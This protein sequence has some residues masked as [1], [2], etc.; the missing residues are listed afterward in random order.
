MVS[1]AIRPFTNPGKIMKLKS[2]AQGNVEV[3]IDLGCTLCL[4]SLQTI[5]KLGI[6]VRTLIRPLKF[7]QVNGL[8]I[9]ESPSC[10]SA[11]Q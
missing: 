8:L 2:I 1:E 6:R 11:N 9:G 3:I 4:I 5:L 10:S 7:E